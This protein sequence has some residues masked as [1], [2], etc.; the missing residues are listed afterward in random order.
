MSQ[1][2]LPKN[3]YTAGRL[4]DA[5]EE[6]HESPQVDLT[7][8]KNKQK[9]FDLSAIDVGQS[10]Q[11][12]SHFDHSAAL[13]NVEEFD[14]TNVVAH[15]QQQGK[16]K[17]HFSQQTYHDINNLGYNQ[18]QKQQQPQQQFDD[19]E[20][21]QQQNLYK[22]YM[23]NNKYSLKGSHGGNSFSSMSYDG[24]KLP[25]IVTQRGSDD[26]DEDDNK[27][28]DPVDAP[29]QIINGIPVANPY[30]IDLNTLK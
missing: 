10:Y 6:L 8:K 14:T 18:K 3:V 13:K 26:D 1:L 9:P 12:V 30:N 25:K 2:K 21:E 17:L 4:K 22:G 24:S 27:V 23:L 28:E 29:I 5:L 20:N 15:Q 16:P 19:S 11:H 7:V